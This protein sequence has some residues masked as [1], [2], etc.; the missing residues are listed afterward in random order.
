M[1]QR[2]VLAA[3]VGGIV[4]FVLGYLIY[5]I[6][7]ADFFDGQGV[8]AVDEPI[9]WAI[10]VGNLVMAILITYIFAQWASISTFGGGFKGGAIIGGLIALSIGLVMH[11]VSGEMTLVGVVAE[12]IVSIVRVGLAGGVIGMLLGR[13]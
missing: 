11:G 6:A 4:L 3:V 12:V 7:L 5:G 1:S 8:G 10:F 2:T 9:L 13:K